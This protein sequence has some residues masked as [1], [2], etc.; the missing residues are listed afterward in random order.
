MPHRLSDEERKQ[1][2]AERNKRY[3]EKYRDKILQYHKEHPHH[4]TRQE[5]R[6]NFNRRTLEQ[7]INEV[8]PILKPY[9]QKLKHLELYKQLY[10]NE[11]DLLATIFL[12]ISNREE[13]THTVEEITPPSKE[14]TPPPP[15]E[16]DP[17]KDALNA[18]R[19]PSKDIRELLG[20]DM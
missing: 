19:T 14:I 10:Q 3:Y 16:P 15:Q 6:T 1:K 11:M 5:R 4:Q 18:D 17:I 7:L 8:D 13:I 12:L 20:L 9:I 2:K